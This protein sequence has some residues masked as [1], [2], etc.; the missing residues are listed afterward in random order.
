MPWYNPFTW[1]ENDC[2]EGPTQETNHG[3]VAA[4]YS[5]TGSTSG[6]SGGDYDHYCPPGVCTPSRV[7]HTARAQRQEAERLDSDS[8]QQLPQGKTVRG[9]LETDARYLLEKYGYQ[10]AMK[11]VHPD[12]LPAENKEY[13]N[14]VT[15]ELNR[16]HAEE[17]SSGFWK[18][19]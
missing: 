8:A 6:D 18:L 16:I 19:R 3:V 7:Q 1:F 10:G 13:G 12:R 4:D 11:I 9:Q 14:N 5:N 2:Y 17:K 15:K